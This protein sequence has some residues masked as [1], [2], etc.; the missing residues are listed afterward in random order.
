MGQICPTVKLKNDLFFDNLEG[1]K[2]PWPTL[3]EWRVPFVPSVYI[4]N[5]IDKYWKD[6]LTEVPMMTK[7]ENLQ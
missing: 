6:S 7:F 3:I 1:E 5:C 4:T 2:S